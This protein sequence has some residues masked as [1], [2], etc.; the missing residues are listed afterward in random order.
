MNNNDL[1]FRGE[2]F[3]WSIEFARYSRLT[4]TC[5]FFASFGAFTDDLKALT[6][7]R[8]QI[9]LHCCS[10]LLLVRPGFF[11]ASPEFVA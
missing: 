7:A 5:Q 3:V 11:L 2:T 8:G 6:G 9:Y 4:H 1:F 10:N